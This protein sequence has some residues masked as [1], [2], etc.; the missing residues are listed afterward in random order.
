MLAAAGGELVARDARE[1]DLPVELWLQQ[2]SPREDAAAAIR[3]ALES[4][5]DGGEATGLR[6]HRA[7]DGTLLITHRWLLAVAR[8]PDGP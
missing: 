3:H 2:A 5:A 6:A 7:D 1:Q 8:T 4:E